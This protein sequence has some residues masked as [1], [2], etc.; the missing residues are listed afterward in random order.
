MSMNSSS[1]A[2]REEDAPHPYLIGPLSRQPKTTGPPNVDLHGTSR[3][4]LFRPIL[5]AIEREFL[6]VGHHYALEVR[7]LSRSKHARLTRS[8]KG[9]ALQEIAL[10]FRA[11]RSTQGAPREMH[12]SRTGSGAPT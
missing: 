11:A 6:S 10:E 7:Y 8:G 9:V 3:T 5:P 12:T 2:Q 4:R 1:P